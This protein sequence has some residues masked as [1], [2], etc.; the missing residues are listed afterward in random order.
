MSSVPLEAL[1]QTLLAELPRSPDVYAQKIDLGAWAALLIRFDAAGYRAASFL[2]DRILTPSMPAAWLPLDRV[3][4][5]AQRTLR[6]RPL[7][8]IFHTGHVGSTLLSRLLDETGVGLALREPLPMRTLADAHDQLGEGYSLLSRAQFERALATSLQLWARGYDATRGVFVKATSSAGR[9][10]ARILATSETSR[11]IYMNVDVEP[12]L[13]TLLAGRNSPID[14]RGHGPERWRRLQA[15]LSGALPALSDL[16]LGELA[17]MSWLSES[18]TQF[19]V[20]GTFGERVMAIDF[21]RYLADVGG[22][23]GRVL[24]HFRVSAEPAYLAKIAGSPTLGRYSKAPEYSYTPAVRAEIL[25][26]SRRENRDEIRKGMHWLE[27]L[28]RSD[29]SIATV[30]RSVGAAANPQ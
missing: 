27:H 9:L 12:Y 13:A 1:A 28:S 21:D 6:P 3:A 24:H 4:E 29:P 7:H 23:M 11:A 26:H 5:V 30:V 16:S 19:E 17:A 14:L 20:V 8:F 22:S 2:D 18:W 10:A 25:R 15:R